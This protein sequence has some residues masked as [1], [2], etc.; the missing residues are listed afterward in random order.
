MCSFEAGE[1]VYWFETLD[2]IAEAFCQLSIGVVC[3]RRK[4]LN[5]CRRLGFWGFK[6]RKS[7]AGEGTLMDHD[8]VLCFALV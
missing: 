5:R 7:L 6:G 3:W 4:S 8:V 1:V 2:E